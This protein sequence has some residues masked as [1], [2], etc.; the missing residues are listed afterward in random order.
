VGRG[1]KAAII[2]ADGQAVT[3]RPGGTI[4]NP[5]YKQL[6]SFSSGGPRNGDSASKPDVTAPGVSI[7][8][9]LV[10]G[11]TKGTTL[12]GTSMASPHVAGVAALV[13]DGNPTWAPLQVKAAIMNTA[14]AGGSVT[15]GYTTRLWGA[16][17]VQ[18][19]RAV[20][21]LGLATTGTNTASLSFG[22]DP[23]SGAYSES[24]P[25][26]LWN[27]SDSPISYALT[28]SSIVTLSVSSITVP[29]HGSATVDATAARSVASLAA[30]PST[31][32]FA[33]G[34]WG[35]VIASANVIRATPTTSAPGV[36]E[37]RIPFTAVPRPL[38]AVS[39][40]ARSAY[41]VS[42]GIARASVPL[43]NTGIHSGTA[44][45][46]AWGLSDPQDLPDVARATND[47]RA[48]GVQSIPAEALTGVAD[49]TDRGLIF[50]INT[51]G[52]WSSA[53]SNEFDIAIYGSNKH[54]PD[55]FVVGVDFGEVTAGDFNGQMASFVITPAGDLVDAWVA[56][57]PANGSTVLLPLLASEIGQTSANA[58]FS[59][60]VT[61][62][63]V[64]D[65]S[66]VDTVAGQAEFSVRKPAV[67]TGDF[68]SLE[69]GESTTL[70]V[71]VDKG[72]LST[73]P[74]K[75]WMVVTL[76]DANGAA[77]ADLV[78]I[79]RP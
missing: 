28:A 50:A 41:S 14:S 38:S 34:L 30:M 35:G 49:P 33:N 18:P 47:I 13:R 59:Y 44:D 5:T 55:F 12:S 71:A 31:S 79:G 11:G 68:L 32:T 9:T 7:V 22:Y 52:R 36:Y 56:D 26:T 19:R 15:S 37:L 39:A 43:T 53:A 21:T 65:S 2:A 77:Q 10:G 67:S 63:S 76:D 72:K 70:D 54:T 78:P 23:V 6:A 8:S 1:A 45:V 51:W 4:A 60:D 66:L 74:A 27:T 64:E 48:V 29:A 25:F 75:G 57:S 16:G 24:R 61:G 62:F 40:G 46:Y 73:A 42:N 20:A 17:L 69:P 58:R 3:L